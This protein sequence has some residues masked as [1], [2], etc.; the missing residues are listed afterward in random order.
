MV[1]P[2]SES[3]GPGFDPQWYFPDAGNPFIASVSKGAAI[4]IGVSTDFQSCRDGA[5]TSWVLTLM[6]GSELGFTEMKKKDNNKM[7]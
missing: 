4:S 6:L 7:K 5:T 1:V 3:R 2:H